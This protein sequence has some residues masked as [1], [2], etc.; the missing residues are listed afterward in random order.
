MQAPSNVV[1]P[2][3]LQRLIARARGGVGQG[4]DAVANNQSALMGGAGGLAG[5][6]LGG[7]AGLGTGIGRNYGEE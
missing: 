6:G 1:D 5:A 3:I 2:N 4:L 7:L